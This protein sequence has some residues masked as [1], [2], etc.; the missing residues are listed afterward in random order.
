MGW[1]KKKIN[2]GQVLVELLVVMGLAAI[3]LPA[4]LTGWATG[5]EGKAQLAAKMQAAAAG[6]EAWEATRSVRERGWTS[7][8]VDGVYHPVPAAG[9]WRLEPGAEVLPDGSTRQ[10]AIASAYRDATGNLAETGT[11]DRSVK[12]VTVTLSWPLP[13]PG[14]IQASTYL[15]RYL[16]N[17]TYLQ[18][19]VADFQAGVKTGTVVTGTAGGEVTLAAGGSGDW[20]QPNLTIAALDLPKNGVANALTAIAGQ[21]F[22]GTGDNASGVSFA[23]VAIA[24]TH[25]PTATVVGTFDGYKT[26]DIFGEPGYAYLATDNN[27]KEIEIVDLSHQPYTQAGYFNASGST[28]ANAVFVAGSVGYMTQGSTFRT[29]DL[30][31][32]TGSRPQ[33]GSRGLAGTGTEIEVVGTYAYV[34]IAGATAEMQILD[35]SNPASPQIVGQADVNGQAARDVFVTPAA[36]RAYLA[37]NESDSQRELFVVDVSTKTGARPTI[38]S[39]DA[40]DMDPK[41]VTVVTGNKAILVGREGEEYQVVD[42]GTETAPVR[43]GGLEVA[44]G[45]N[46]VASVLE[47]DGDAYSYIIT[48]DAG[49]ELRIIEGGP[50]GSLV[51]T[52]TFESAAFDAGYTTAFNRI[53]I[54]ALTPAQTTLQAQVAV[55]ADCLNY[56]FVGPDG[57]SGTFYTSAGGAVPV[58]VNPGRCFKYKLYLESLDRIT[59]PVFYDL[60]VNYS[61]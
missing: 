58:G 19:S 1:W 2:T 16:D 27:S 20:C 54:T 50:G 9:Q 49:G 61:P 15:T 35:V 60:T 33:L 11:E 51:P 3:L 52:G 30:S 4:I 17:L 18:T 41:G 22:A 25:P 5:R 42:I 46:G 14:Q 38:G 57:T 7:F 37:T 31:S 40:S 26:N 10:V 24:D 23:N 48:G 55:S 45:V 6:R 32:K 47:P 34:S 29:F 53:W 12:K 56:T 39:Y 44:A 36:T 59:A 43:C 13:R 28:D 8:A 21:A